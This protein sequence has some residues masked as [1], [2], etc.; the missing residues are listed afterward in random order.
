[1]KPFTTSYGTTITAATMQRVVDRTLAG[2]D[3]ERILNEEIRDPIPEHD[4][5]MEE[6]MEVLREGEERAGI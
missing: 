3:W 1:M 6:A 4:D 5:D 2:E